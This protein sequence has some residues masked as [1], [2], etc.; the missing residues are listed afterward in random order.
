MLSHSPFGLGH[1]YRY[2]PDQRIPTRPITGE[3]WKIS[4]RTSG[5][6]KS[7]TLHVTR[8][9]SSEHLQLT[10]IGPAQSQD[11]GPYGETAKF[12][13]ADTH[14]A[15]AAARS[16]EYP[17]EK[18]W[19][20]ELAPLERYENVAYWLET[21]SG[22]R[23][24]H[25]SAEALAWESDDQNF[26][27]SVG[28][29][30]PSISLGKT[31]LLKDSHGTV[32]RLQTTLP[33]KTTDK[34]I[35]FG[36]RFHSV[37]QVGHFVDAV[38]YEEYKGQGHRTYLP[39]PFGIVIGSGFGF[40]IRTSTP[41]RYD[42]GVTNPDELRIEIDITPR[43]THCEI[44]GYLGSPIDV[45][46]QYLAEFPSPKNPPS[47]IYSLWG[48][49]NE[50]NTQKRV[51]NEISQSIALGIDLGVVVIE[52]W[53]DETTFT[54]FRDGQYQAT[55]GSRGLK[56]SEIKYPTDGAW[57]NPQQMIEEMHEKNI[58]VILWQNPVIKDMQGV[59]DAQEEA[60]WNYA[61]KN[62][63]V[64]KDE[65]GDPYR[66]RG[67]WLRHGLL[68]DLTDAKVR[69]WWADLHRYLV[70]ELGVDGFKTDGGE[71]AWGQDLQ[72]LDGKT[73]L[74]KNNLLPVAYAQTFHE[75]MIDSKKDGVTFSRSGFAGSSSFPTFW[76]G[77]EDST[78]EA[79]R[80]SIRAGITASASGIF[81][82]DGI[83]V[84]LAVPY[85]A[86]NFICEAPQWRPSVQ[87]CNFILNTITI[88]FHPTIELLGISRFNTK[89]LKLL[90][91]SATSQV[92]ENHLS[93]ISPKRARWQ[94]K[95]D[96]R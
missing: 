91:F 94:F 16:G 35:G 83:S 44:V 87:L 5:E 19:E 64:V 27:K 93:P 46:R 61:I 4:A 82:G 42:V 69:R 34:V 62:N 55:D 78:W 14:L 45:V 89:I 22:E 23:T 90:K 33:L 26:L 71:H 2:E 63:L 24:V 10:F 65:I 70:T 43:Q 6:I 81:F 50:W 40:Y 68:P 30:P 67:F 72:Y 21:D 52:A 28:S 1:P 60:I 9:H 37:N 7:V 17:G 95:L 3:K 54:V 38:V 84:D 75:L 88:E 41:S 8:A 29:F 59:P 49:S 56:A 77:D 12:I 58:K 11:F 57:P 47:W 32:F 79:Y 86:L 92:F 74:E 80:A 20:I 18:T 39:A 13:E 36:E 85:R 25:F 73:G 31:R 66:V 15:D 51:E 53:S 96:V 76:A 48:S